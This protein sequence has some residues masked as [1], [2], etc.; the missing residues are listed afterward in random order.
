MANLDFGMMSEIKPY[1]R[2]DLMEA[3][4]HMVNRDFEGL[5][6]I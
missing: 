3:I 5:A 2:M 4:V 1:Q 6:V